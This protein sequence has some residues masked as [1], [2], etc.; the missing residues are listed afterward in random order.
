[1]DRRTDGL[2]VKQLQQ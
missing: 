1:M 2:N